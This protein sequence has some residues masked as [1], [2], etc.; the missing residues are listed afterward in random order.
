MYSYSHFH[1]LPYIQYNNDLICIFLTQK[2]QNKVVESG[3]TKK[4]SIVLLFKSVTK[5]KN[6]LK[7]LRDYCERYFHRLSK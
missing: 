2:Y 6:S 7:P 5:V 1:L 4:N 3:L